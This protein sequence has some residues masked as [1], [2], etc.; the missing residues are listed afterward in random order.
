MTTRLAPIFTRRGARAQVL[1]AGL[2]LGLPVHA[3]QPL[4]CL[5]EPNRVVELGSPVIGVLEQVH[6]DRGANVRMGQVVATLKADVERASADV[7]KS[8]AQAVADVQAAIANRDYNRQH[9]TRAEELVKKNFIANQ[10]L[11]QAK[12]EA[13]VAE[14]RLAQ[15][16]EQQRIWDREYDMARAQLALRSLVSPLTG[17]VVERYLHPG[18]RVE[19][20]AVMKLAALNPLRVEVFMP[21][22][23]Y[24]EVQPGMTAKVYPDLPDAGEHNARVI[25]VDRIIDPASNTFRVRLELPNPGNALPA[26]LRCKVAIGD[27]VVESG[28]DPNKA[29]V[30]SSLAPAKPAQPAPPRSMSP[31]PAKPATAAAPKASMAPEA[32]DR[33][34]LQALEAWRKSWASRDLAGYLSA[35]AADFR[36]DAPS[37][38]HWLKQ[39]ETRIG[40]AGDIN[41]RISDARVHPLDDR[42]ARVEFRQSYRSANFSSDTWKSLLMVLEQGRW[43]IREERAGR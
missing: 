10:A 12:T 17:V 29:L 19:D 4:G 34:V 5:I 35:Y 16:R 22:A 14:Q 1:M 20:R 28:G 9:L 6:V 32:A 33:G 18:E 37:R 43:L 42:R 8:R 23:S 41:I 7:A 13:D 3:A 24:R 21:T 36:G 2:M 30:P 26:G 27:Q 38:A 25:L 39:R 11:D 40:K 15:A 31:T